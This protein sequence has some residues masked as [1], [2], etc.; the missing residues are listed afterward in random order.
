MTCAEKGFM[1][2]RMMTHC[3][4]KGPNECTMVRGALSRIVEQHVRAKILRG[5]DSMGK[6]KIKRKNM[7][8]TYQEG[9]STEEKLYTMQGPRK[10]TAG[11]ALASVFLHT[12][13]RL[14]EMLNFENYYCS[15]V[16]RK[17]GSWRPDTL[18]G[19]WALERDIYK[20]NG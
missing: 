12:G 7:H 11:G 19:A 13:T 20:E 14:K 1:M 18:D 6:T 4:N 5:V 16:A 2:S 17:V 10:D 15:S 3:S 8:R 9:L